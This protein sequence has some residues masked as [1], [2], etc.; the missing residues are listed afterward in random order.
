MSEPLTGVTPELEQL[1]GSQEAEDLLDIVVELV[2]V[3]A[4]AQSVEQLRQSF[5][6]M[7]AP[8]DKTISELG[9]TVTDEAWINHTLRARIPARGLRELS[10]LAT[11]RALDVPHKLEAD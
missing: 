2:Q 6:S 9:G 5:G 10:Q 11:V 7:R 3:P 4:A 1:A 8:V